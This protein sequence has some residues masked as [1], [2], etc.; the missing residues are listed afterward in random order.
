M[1]AD[2]STYWKYF[3]WCGHE[4]MVATNSVWA[5]GYLKRVGKKSTQVGCTCLDRRDIQARD[6]S[7]VP[8]SHPSS[9]GN[10][11]V[12]REFLNDLLD[13]RVGKV[14]WL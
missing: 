4:E 12:G 13:V 7:S 2:V 5:I 3:G 11:F 1:H 10:G 8:K 6:L 14:R 9:Q